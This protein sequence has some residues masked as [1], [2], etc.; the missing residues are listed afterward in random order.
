MLTEWS[1]GKRGAFRLPGSNVT[2]TPVTNVMETILSSGGLGTSNSARREN[3]GHL[4]SFAAL[5]TPDGV[6]WLVPAGNRR[7][8]LRGF[9]NYSPFALRARV[10]KKVLMSAAR[11]NM[12]SH[13]STEVLV[14]SDGPLELEQLIGR[15]T[16]EKDVS[17]CIA[18]GTATRFQKLT[19]QVLD[20]KGKPLAFIKL[21]MNAAAAER[22]RHEASVLRELAE[23]PM[24]TSVPRVMFDGPWGDNL[25]LL[26]ISPAP[27]KTSPLRLSAEHKAFLSELGAQGSFFR[28]AGAVLNDVLDDV[29]QNA[30][31]EKFQTVA[32]TAL[33]QA[34]REV[35]NMPVQCG[36]IHGDF[37]PWNLCISE[38]R[39]FGFDW[40]SS[41][42]GVPLLWDSLHFQAQVAG[43]VKRGDLSW[44]DSY[45]D[46]PVRRALLLAYAVR[47]LCQAKNEETPN[48]G[49]ISMRKQIIEELRGFSVCA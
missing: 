14:R 17:F 22:I 8:A 18:V 44:M 21:P 1:L 32:V 29:T 3:G 24:Q 16:G 35:A 20:Q 33:L 42:F 15:V 40:E 19:I 10:L 46:T 2:P 43:L 13:I 11:L 37:A 47:S 5:P 6:K 36:R 28:P 39:L 7:A 41:E 4:T 38:G 49:M 12:L 45:L 30:T 25:H 31:L 23:T 34:K 27:G 48:P 9:Q 26:M